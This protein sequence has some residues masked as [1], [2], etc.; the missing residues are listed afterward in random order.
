M[1]KDNIYL[2]LICN[3]NDVQNRNTAQQTTKPAG[4]SAVLQATSS[5]STSAAGRG[6]LPCQLLWLNIA[7]VTQHH[8]THSVSNMYSNITTDA[9]KALAS[10][11]KHIIRQRSSTVTTTVQQTLHQGNAWCQSCNI[12]A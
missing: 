4:L 7:K 6:K 1:N 9:S 10:R 2:A 5:L 12:E 8:I 11:S 3:P